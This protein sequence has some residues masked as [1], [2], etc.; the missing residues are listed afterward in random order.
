MLIP[1][2]S[3]DK[4]SPA[5]YRPLCLLSEAGM[6]LERILMVRITEHLNISGPDL[7]DHQY[8]FRQG[9]STIDA[10]SRVVSLAE[11]AIG[12]GGVALAVSVDIVNAFNT[13]P[14]RAV[15]ESLERHKLPEYLVRIVYD[16]LTGRCV[17]YKEKRRHTQREIN[18]GVPQGSVLGPLLWNLEY[19]KVLQTVLPAGGHVTCY[20]DDTLLVAC[21]RNWTRTIRI[22]EVAVAE[23]VQIISD[24]GLEIAAQKTEATWLHGLRQ[25]KRPPLAWVA[26]KGERIPVGQ[27]IKYLGVVP[28]SRLKYEAHFT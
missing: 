18:R 21:G 5:A 14:W 27:R 8:G 23:L 24:V 6:I 10:I 17:E 13:V 3:K 15:R 20:A 4:V 1:K 7:H 2:Q 26:V 22:M 19:N 28:D 16:Y 25:N 12:Q 11:G 9:R